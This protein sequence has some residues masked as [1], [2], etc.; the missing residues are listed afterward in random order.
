MRTY[1]LDY[2]PAVSQLAGIGRYTKILAESM[3]PMLGSEESLRLFYCDFRRHLKRSPAEGV[4]T[5]A[6]RLFPGGLLQHFWTR[7]NTPPFD[8]FSGRADVFHF[9]NFF[10][11]P[12]TRG[13]VITTVHDMSYERY[14]QFAAA[15][16]CFV[17][18][19]GVGRSI[20]ASDAVLTISE[21]SKR[22]IEEIHP[23]AKG[24][25]F[26]TYPGIG[27]DFS[28]ATPE[29]VR[30]IKRKLGLTRPFLLTVGTIEPRKN[31]EFLVDVFERL[32]PEGYDLV[33]SGAPGWRYDSIF[34]RFEGT[35]F[36]KQFHYVRYVPDGGL[37]AL[38]SAAALYVTPSH[39]EGFGF[40]PLEA[41][42]CGAPVLSSN[43]GSLPEVLG[44]AATI[45]NGFDADEWAQAALRV[46]QSSQ[47]ELDAR[48]AHGIAHARSFTW[49]RCVRQTLDQYRKVANG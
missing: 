12:V 18:K 21:F 47:Q 45:V 15:Y 13:K 40:P 30:E 5:R 37:T 17:L 43:G 25:V 32:A 29:A 7:Y 33:V 6:F 49:E 20:Q 14:P 28:P 3:A 8:W 27:A 31:L 23:Y 39:Y 41:M 24:K 42:A 10:A 46:L 16:N 19:K 11:R 26:V 2:Q 38:Y 36:P 9:T 1:C 35:R 4:E 48:R 44:D 22:E 34:A